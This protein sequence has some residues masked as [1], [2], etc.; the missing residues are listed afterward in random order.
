MRHGPSPL[1]SPRPRPTSGGRPIA[2]PRLAALA[3]V[4]SSARE[5][6]LAEAGVLLVMVIWAGNFVVVKSALAEL[7]PVAFTMLRFILAS[8]ILLAVCRVR[9]GS[10]LL[11]RRDLAQLAVLG[12]IGFAIYQ[13][14][15]TTA[16]DQ[17]TAADSALLI[18]ATPIVTALVAGA[19]RSDELTPLMLLGALVSFA[20][21]ALVVVAGADGAFGSRAIGNLLTVAAAVCWAIYVAFGAPVL[22]RHSPLRT[23]AWTVTFGT[24]FLLPLGT[25]ELVQGNPHPSAASLLAIL[26]AGIFSIAIG[27][28]L[29]FWG[30]KV[31]GPTRTAN[32]QFLVPALAVVLAAAFLAEQIRAEQVLGGIVIVLGIFVARG[33]WRARPGLARA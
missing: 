14:L 20:G 13:A 1:P 21:V 22:R 29:Q 2:Q 33:G 18:A 10:L 30:V 15:W 17:T 11:P 26:Y 23:T 31:L 6:H 16:L 32:F 12:A 4:A 8:G 9:E 7:P 24:L 28:V 25:W 27:N 5:R 3:R 19:I